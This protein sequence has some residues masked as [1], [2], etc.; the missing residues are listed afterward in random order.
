MRTSHN[1]QHHTAPKKVSPVQQHMLDFLHSFEY[2]GE[3]C[4]EC[5]HPWTEN[6]Q[7]HHRTCSC[8]VSYHGMHRYH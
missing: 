5:G 7:L 2:R 8:Y 1:T 6:G 3:R 4:E